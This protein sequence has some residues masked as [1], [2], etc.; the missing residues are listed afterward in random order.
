MAQPTQPGYPPS[1]ERRIRIRRIFGTLVCLV[2]AS[3][4]TPLH[5]A[6]L[7]TSPYARTHTLLNGDWQVIIDPYGTGAVDYRRRPRADGFF[8]DAKAKND[9]DLIEYAFTNANT[10]RVPGDWNTQRP[11][12]LYYEGNVWYCKRFSVA[13][14][15][16][17]RYFMRF[18]AA[19]YRTNVYLNG[20]HVGAH[21]GGF[22]PFEFE[23]TEYVHA[24]QNT[25]V[26][27][28]DNTRDRDGV[29]TDQTDWW[30]YGGITRDVLLIDTPQTFIRHY[31]LQ[32]DPAN[33]DQIIGTV[34][35]D[36]PQQQ[37]AGHVAIPAAD[38]RVAFETNDAG[39]AA[40]KLP[41]STLD[42]WSPDRPRLYATTISCETNTLTDKIGFRTVATDK[43][44]ILLNGKPIFLRGICIHEEALDNLGRA[45][46]RAQ[47]EALLARAKELNCNFVRLAHYPHNEWMLRT[48]D[49]MG[50]LV[51]AEIPVYWTVNFD[52]A[53]TLANA[54]QQLTE[55]IERDQN[56]A[57]IAIWSVANETPRS[58]ARLTFLRSLIDHARSLDDT[59]LISA[60]LETHYEDSNTIVIEDPLGAYLDVLGCNEYI[61][62][63]DGPPAK[64]KS[65]R[66]KTPY[67]KPL[68]IS[69]F[70]AGAKFGH[71][72]APSKRWTEDYQSDV[73]RQ[74][75]DML[76]RI[77]FL[78]GTSPWILK[79]F[80][81]PRRLLPDIQDGWNRKGLLSEKGEKK[82]AFDVLRGWYHAKRPN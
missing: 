47:A 81:S 7:I 32:L 68:V 35:L 70:G 1:Q 13:P 30:N 38:V 77:P 46:S 11:E 14:Q 8:R 56:R 50:L 19:N 66:W 79:D 76:D 57:C 37:Q 40:I 53:E 9:T 26:V 73:Y 51:W 3:P 43:H 24:G 22:T 63:Y 59:R 18:E 61:G 64:A 6:E 39:R 58:A 27:Q 72:G 29:P 20:K 52:S 5:A 44:Q 82:Q 25:L 12:L 23:I 54:K 10:L 16:D 48:A 4:P 65:L 71:H 36:G 28:V 69:E 42:R 67:Q 2:L 17:R 21:V 45:F 75:I 55:M 33:P 34:Q 49:E 62:W 78:A 41:A 15:K 74:Q 60:A 31:Q 80:R